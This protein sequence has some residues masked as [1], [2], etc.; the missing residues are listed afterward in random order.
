[1]KKIVIGFISIYQLFVSPLLK[2]L[3]G[4]S[5]VCRY[6]PTCS[7]YA[8]NAIRKYGIRKGGYLAVK[9]LLSCQ[10][11]AKTEAVI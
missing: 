1:M 9:R 11:F 3:L 7:Q 6:N 5:A 8:K 10:P 2:Q 4:T